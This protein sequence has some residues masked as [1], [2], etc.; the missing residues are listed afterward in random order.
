MA[1]TFPVFRCGPGDEPLV[2]GILDASVD[3]LVGKGHVDQWGTQPFSEL[4]SR[5]SQVEDMLARS[6]LAL[7]AGTRSAPLGV[8]VLGPP[9]GHVPAADGPESYVVLL[10]STHAPGARGV[11]RFLLERAHEFAKEQGSERL[12][13]D[14]FAGNDGRLVA[15][16]ERCGFRPCDTFQVGTWRGVVLDRP[17]E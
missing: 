6:S 16:Y 11:G 1:T 17:V 14:C 10:A 3:W 13:V 8:L 9:P 15:F 4:P 12:R 2:L 5:R 7:V